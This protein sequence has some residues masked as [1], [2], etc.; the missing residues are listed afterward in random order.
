MKKM[1]FLTLLILVLPFAAIGILLFYNINVFD[2]PD[3][4]YGYMAF[5]GTVLLGAVALAQSHKANRINDRL[6]DMQE[7]LQRFQIKEKAACVDIAPVIIDK[8]RN[9][10]VVNDDET[11]N[12]FDVVNQQYEYFFF[13]DCPDVNR[14]KGKLFNMVFELKNISNNVLKEIYIEDLKV[15][16]IIT[17]ASD[18]AEEKENIREYIY[19]DSQGY[20]QCLVRPNETVKIC[21]KI[22]MDEYDMTNESFCVNFN[23]STM[24]VYNVI[25]SENVTLQRNN[26]VDTKDR[27]F[28]KIDRCYFVNMPEA[29]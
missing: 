4:W 10:F 16:D 23:L 27:V 26:V 9:Y 21:L 15:F 20:A 13:L 22:D 7:E 2:N 28:V 18:V 25:F 17:N 11:E 6:L 5:F 3:F 1:F 24:S 19:E 8:Q 29:V 14:E 12:E